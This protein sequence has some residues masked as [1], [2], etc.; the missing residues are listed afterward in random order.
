[1]LLLVHLVLFIAGS[2]FYICDFL[3]QLPTGSYPI[4]MFL[5]PIG[6]AC[7]FLFLALAWIFERVGIPIYKR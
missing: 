2:A 5:I 7:V 3:P 4:L 6:L 1:L